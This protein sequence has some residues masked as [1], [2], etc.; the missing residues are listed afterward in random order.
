MGKI[1]HGL[2]KHPL[3]RTWKGIKNRCYNTNDK[4]YKDY[5]ERGMSLMMW[6]SATRACG[7]SLA[8]HQPS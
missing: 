2:S 6:T 8:M 1:K 4:N 7:I 3:Y 5:G